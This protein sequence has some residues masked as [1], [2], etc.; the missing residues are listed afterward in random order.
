MVNFHHAAVNAT[1]QPP[2]CARLPWIRLPPDRGKI[3]CITRPPIFPTTQARRPQVLTSVIFCIKIILFG[4]LATNSTASF[5]YRPHGTWR[6]PPRSDA[7][8]YTSFNTP[9]FTQLQYQQGYMPRPSPQATPYQ[10]PRRNATPPTS[11]QDHRQLPFHQ[12][13]EATPHR[14]QNLYNPVTKPP[15]MPSPNANDAAAAATGTGQPT[16]AQ[17][18]I[19]QIIRGLAP[20]QIASILQSARS[21]NTDETTP[22]TAATTTTPISP[23]NGGQ[24]GLLAA[25]E[26]ARK[27]NLDDYQ[28]QE[29]CITN[30]QSL[31]ELTGRPCVYLHFSVNT[32]NNTSVISLPA[33]KAAITAM[34]AANCPD[35]QAEIL[36]CEHL[37]MPAGGRPRGVCVISPASCNQ[38]DEAGFQFPITSINKLHLF[39]ASLCNPNLQGGL[40]DIHPLVMGESI[41]F[42]LDA[43]NASQQHARAVLGGI[44]ATILQPSTSSNNKSHADVLSCRHLGRLLYKSVGDLIEAKEGTRPPLLQSTNSH[45]INSAIS[46]KLISAKGKQPVI[47]IVFA[48]NC[49]A[50]AEVMLS[51]LPTSEG[52]FT[53]LPLLPITTSE[54]IHVTI[55]PFDQPKNEA[56][57]Q[58]AR[59]GNAKTMKDLHVVHNVRLA[60]IDIDILPEMAAA[61]PDCIGILPNF[62]NGPINPT[63]NFIFNKNFETPQYDASSVTDK[64]CA[65]EAYRNCR[66]L[67]SSPPQ[68]NPPAPNTYKQAATSAKSATNSSVAALQQSYATGRI[69]RALNRYTYY[70]VINSKGGSALMGVY[71]S[72][73]DIMRKL[74]DNISHSRII[75]C[76]TEKE[77]YAKLEEFYTGIDTAEK[78]EEWRNNTPVDECNF[79]N[80]SQIV[81]SRVICGNY[82]PLDRR[83]LIPPDKRETYAPAD[84]PNIHL[85][86]AAVPTDQQSR[87]RTSCNATPQAS[88]QPATSPHRPFSTIHTAQPSEAHDDE[89]SQLSHH[90]SSISISAAQQ[91]KKT[92]N[93]VSAPNQDL[94]TIQATIPAPT[95]KEETL[96]ILRQWVAGTEW[97]STAVNS[98][99][100]TAIAFH[101]TFQQSYFQFESASIATGVLT[102]LYTSLEDASSYCFQIVKPP[103]SVSHMAEPTPAT[104]HTGPSKCPFPCVECF[105]HLNYY[106]HDALISTTAET[107]QKHDIAKC[108]KCNLILPSDG[109]ASHQASAHPPPQQESTVPPPESTVVCDQRPD[110]SQHI[111]EA[112]R[113]ICPPHRIDELTALIS[114][115]PPHELLQIVM[116]WTRAPSNVHP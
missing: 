103:P 4:H 62:A 13:H 80:R 48:A 29:R 113:L 45:T 88:P 11:L 86:R 1:K 107:L 36:K 40:R 100:P 76:N 60:I 41:S 32:K 66:P 51:A 5:H 57:F 89:M 84:A 74:A 10:F 93:N 83:C 98:L 61:L 65:I 72:T 52:H 49:T 73:W 47:A 21:T 18:A 22:T 50:L 44:G 101:P 91:S 35:V 71:Y 19:L 90:T 78:A 94:T 54:V 58:V 6:R 104:T 82:L 42:F 56:L 34:L 114:S 14:A 105:N 17:E 26:A 28:R 112:C 2:W 37:P 70:V 39:V 30:T 87:K 68:G 23:S 3:T 79:T 95:N 77:A 106:H 97:E 116:E 96:H 24:S 25:Q 38:H 9:L 8:L 63:F 64:V 15:T 85:R 12:H 75:Q 43:V 20:E 33:I 59:D 99:T 53:P 92:R 110:P 81:Q 108:A 69:G 7:S 109:L 67:Q 115:T 16:A 46:T 111:I 27:A 55:A 31:E 102:H